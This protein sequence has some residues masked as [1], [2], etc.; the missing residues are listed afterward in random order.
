MAILVCCALA[1]S[2]NESGSDV[3]SVK[4]QFITTRVEGFI[5]RFALKVVCKSEEPPY[6]TN[7]IIY[8]N[9]YWWIK[10]SQKFTVSV[11]HL[12]I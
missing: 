6:V 5:T 10:A 12:W 7:R 8:A 2:G 9:I 11:A 1:G 3:V 4:I